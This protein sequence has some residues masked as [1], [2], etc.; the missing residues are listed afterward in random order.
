MFAKTKK[1][2]IP[3][4]PINSVSGS[5]RSEASSSPRSEASSSPRSN[6]SSPN[7][8]KRM[9][10]Q[11][12]DKIMGLRPPTPENS[13][14]TSPSSLRPMTPSEQEE[15]ADIRAQAEE[16]LEI[17]RNVTE[18]W[19]NTHGKNPMTLDD[20]ADIKRLTKEAL[21]NAGF[22]D[23]FNTGG[24]TRKGKG[25]GQKIRKGRSQKRR[26]S[27]KHKKRSRRSRR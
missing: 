24:K 9:A 22:T 3:V 5:P 26:G 14:E 25:R 7:F 20:Y 21:I 1:Y 2:N 27:R 16:E 19:R 17:G 4:K 6:T 13:T 15:L 8:F 10:D 18:Q 23:G 12:K 11:A